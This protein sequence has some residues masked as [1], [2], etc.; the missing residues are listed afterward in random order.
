[1]CDVTYI[2]YFIVVI[3]L[4]LLFFIIKDRKIETGTWKWQFRS[5]SPSEML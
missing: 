2:V 1:M 5:Y 4:L 3:L